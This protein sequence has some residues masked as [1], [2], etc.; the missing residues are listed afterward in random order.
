MRAVLGT[1]ASLHVRHVVWLAFM[2][3]IPLGV[4]STKGWYEG[5]MA[6][7]WLCFGQGLMLLL[8]KI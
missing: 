2:T 1:F 4:A 8:C 7:V 3:G 6:L 5:L